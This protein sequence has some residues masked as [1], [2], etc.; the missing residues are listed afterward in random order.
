MAS[1]SGD[2]RDVV[3]TR[4]RARCE[5]CQT[6]ERIVMNLEVDHVIP[7]SQ[8]GPSTADNLC[9]SCRNCNSS[10]HDHLV[11]IDPLTGNEERLFNPRRDVWDEHFHWESD[12]IVLHSRTPIGR[13]TVARLRIN[14]PIARS[15]RTLWV[16]VGWHPPQD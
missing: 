4:A 3:R 9:F 10:K 6:Q 11:G 7:E 16:S 2:L 13:A 5:Y 8:G 1:I 15:A 12:G 14:R